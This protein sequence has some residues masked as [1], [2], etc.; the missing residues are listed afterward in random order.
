MALPNLALCFVLHPASPLPTPEVPRLALLFPCPAVPLTC[1]IPHAL[2]VCYISC[3]WSPSPSPCHSVSA[4]R[5]VL[6]LFTRVFPAPRIVFDVAGTQPILPNRSGKA[7][8]KE[9][10]RKWSCF[11]FAEYL[12]NNTCTV[13]N[14]ID[15]YIL[16]DNYCWKDEIAGNFLSCVS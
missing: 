14:I 8:Y 2:P 12:N 16:D 6:P 11:C 4:V 1:H 5:A 10:D 3:L 13:E 7:T 9:M 15:R